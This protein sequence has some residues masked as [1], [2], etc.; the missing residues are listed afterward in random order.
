MLVHSVPVRFLCVCTFRLLCRP[1]CHSFAWPISPFYGAFLRDWKMIHSG[2]NMSIVSAGDMVLMLLWLCVAHS[3][4][5]HRA[6]LHDVLSRAADVKENS[7]IC[8]CVVSTFEHKAYIQSLCIFTFALISFIDIFSIGIC[9]QFKE[10]SFTYGKKNARFSATIWYEPPC[11][12]ESAKAYALT[13][14]I[15]TI[16]SWKLNGFA[17][18]RQE[19]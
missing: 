16:S 17:T 5:A 9:D 10:K 2:L 6:S 4:S 8:G 18:G 1:L 13:W 7:T 14:S 15:G 3:M 12:C 19:V 11:F